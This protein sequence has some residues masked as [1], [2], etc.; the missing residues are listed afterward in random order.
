MSR[1]WLGNLGRFRFAIVLFGLALLWPGQSL[2]D[3]GA[4][5]QARLLKDLKYL[6][7]DE[8]EGRG[9]GTKGINLA[10]DYIARGFA[11]AGLKPAGDN[12]TYFQNFQVSGGARIEKPA[13]L[14]LT[15]P[16]GQTITLKTDEQ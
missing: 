8:C 15:G 11:Q 12:G 1:L 10:A 13:T 3:D 6:T 5:A 9:V 16:L 14:V 2:A 4:D 7:S